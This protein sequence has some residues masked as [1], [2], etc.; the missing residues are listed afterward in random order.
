MRGGTPDG[1]PLIGSADIQS[2]ADLGNSFQMIRD[3]KPFPFGRDAVMLLVVLILLP[4]LPLV[5]TMIPL[6][7]LI[8]KLL[9]AVI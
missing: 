6:E 9:G 8:T 4:G 3:I 2:L 1:E 5:L 7:E